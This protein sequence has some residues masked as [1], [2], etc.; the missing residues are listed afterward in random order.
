MAP[1][2]AAKQVTK[3]AEQQQAQ[4]A[5]NNQAIDSAKHIFVKTGV[6]ALQTADNVCVVR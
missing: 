1:E 2:H 3:H 6:S 5:S 4:V